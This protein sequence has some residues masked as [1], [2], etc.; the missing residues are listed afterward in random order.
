MDIAKAAH[1]YRAGAE[2]ANIHHHLERRLKCTIG[3]LNPDG[4]I[5]LAF[6]ILL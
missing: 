3:T 2:Q 6:V 4:S 1:A 5:H